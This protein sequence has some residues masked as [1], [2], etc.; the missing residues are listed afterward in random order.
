MNIIDWANYHIAS[1][2]FTPTALSRAHACKN[3]NNQWYT[4]AQAH[5]YNNDLG[6]TCRCC[7][8][9]KSETIAFII[10]CPSRAQTHN[11]YCPQVTAHLQACRIDDHL[12]KALE[13]G[14]EVVLSDTES[15]QWE[16]WSGNEEGSVIE[17]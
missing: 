13:L 6:P 16:T 12:L 7:Q 14:M 15:H 3:F 9:N 10:G 1:K 5:K 2:S 8:S 11:E 4:D 17:R